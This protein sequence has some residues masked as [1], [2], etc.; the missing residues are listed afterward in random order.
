M[1]QRLVSPAQRPGSVSEL[2]DELAPQGLAMP[3]TR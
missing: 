2:G 1:S 3:A